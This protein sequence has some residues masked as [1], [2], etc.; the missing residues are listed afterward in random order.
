MVLNKCTL[1]EGP[2]VAEE[3][4]MVFFITELGQRDSNAI[5]SVGRSLIGKEKCESIVEHEHQEQVELD[6]KELVKETQV[7][8]QKQAPLFSN[9]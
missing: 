7:F 5:A 1:R 2:T 9:D 4:L 3:K 6:C 8:I